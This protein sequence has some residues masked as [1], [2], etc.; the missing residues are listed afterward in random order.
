MHPNLGGK[1]LAV[2][3]RLGS[4]IAKEARTELAVEG[5]NR[6]LRTSLRRSDHT[7]EMLVTRQGKLRVSEGWSRGPPPSRPTNGALAR[8]RGAPA[9]SKAFRTDDFYAARDQRR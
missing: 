7:L 9:V 2:R 1:I 4:E 8:A 5:C 3:G 6:P